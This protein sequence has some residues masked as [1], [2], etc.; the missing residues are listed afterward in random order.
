MKGVQASM[1]KGSVPRI[2]SFRLSENDA[3]AIESS[4]V[5]DGAL[6]NFFA[7]A[8]ILTIESFKSMKTVTDPCLQCIVR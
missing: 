3:V 5:D 1:E 6:P 2:A 8:S 7:E 4:T